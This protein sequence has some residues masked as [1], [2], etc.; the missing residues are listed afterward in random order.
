MLSAAVRL[1]YPFHVLTCLPATFTRRKSGLPTPPVGVAAALPAT[2]LSINFS[3]ARPPPV[4]SRVEASYSYV[5]APG[6]WCRLWCALGCRDRKLN[7]KL[8]GFALQNRVAAMQQRGQADIACGGPKGPG[9]TTPPA[10][11][12]RVSRYSGVHG[13]VPGSPA[14]PRYST[15]EQVSGWTGPD[16]GF[17]RRE[18]GARRKAKYSCAPVRLWMG[19]RQCDML[20]VR[21]RTSADMQLTPRPPPRRLHRPYRCRW[22][23]G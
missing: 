1:L 14:K 4:M 13:T 10:Q 22:T 11:G 19:A 20:L 15:V 23:A 17:S 21:R 8:E 9:F 6:P 3:I 18:R 2:D 5:S 7:M 16:A 12:V